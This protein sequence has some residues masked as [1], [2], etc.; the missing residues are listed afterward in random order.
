MPNIKVRLLLNLSLLLTFLGSRHCTSAMF[1]VVLIHRSQWSCFR[2]GFLALRVTSA[3]PRNRHFDP[4]GFY[5]IPTYCLVSVY[6]PVRAVDQFNHW[7]NS[8]WHRWFREEGCH[9]FCRFVKLIS[10]KK[11]KIIHWLYTFFLNLQ[12]QWSTHS[13]LRGR[14]GQLSTMKR[15]LRWSIYIIS[16]CLQGFTQSLYV[17]QLEFPGNRS[18]LISVVTGTD[19]LMP[20]IKTMARQP[21]TPEQK[22][23]MGSLIPLNKHYWQTALQYIQGQ[24]LWTPYTLDQMLWTDGLM[25]LNKTYGLTALLYVYPLSNLWPASIIP[26]NKC[27]VR[28]ALNPW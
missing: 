27:H 24:N 14:I 15:V 22:L 26:L 19:G 28:T 17:E 13:P 5:W 10:L 8:T 25:P 9:Y 18:E 6:R 12:N 11:R 1:Q 2:R 21:D 20:L 7:L 16:L 3:S 4:L 23:L